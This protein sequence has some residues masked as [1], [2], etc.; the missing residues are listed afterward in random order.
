[1]LYSAP[2]YFLSPWRLAASFLAV[3]MTSLSRALVVV[4]RS[5][6]VVCRSYADRTTVVARAFALGVPPGSIRA[7]ASTFHAIVRLS[8]WR[9]CFR[10]G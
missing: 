10:F 1:M 4:A 8:Q 6:P 3:R 9:L 7:S 2:I 5:A